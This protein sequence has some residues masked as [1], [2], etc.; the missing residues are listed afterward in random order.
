MSIQEK[1][2]FSL[3]HPLP[4]QKRDPGL[5]GFGIGQALPREW[6][7]VHSKIGCRDMGVRV[8]GSAV[9]MV[10]VLLLTSGD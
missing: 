9:V 8:K 4:S 5:W 7:V 2:I 6:P 10:I 3:S 1:E